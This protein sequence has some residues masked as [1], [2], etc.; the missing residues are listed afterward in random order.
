M[1]KI[2]KNFEQKD[3]DKIIV[4]KFEDLICEPQMTTKEVCN[5][6]N[7][8]WDDNL[9]DPTFRGEKWHGDSSFE[10]YHGL[11]NKPLE[12]SR[13]QFNPKEKLMISLCLDQF[14]T[15]FDYVS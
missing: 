1:W 8:A 15:R 2:I 12:T 13:I 6:L 7:I 10:R 5:F 4:I 3:P 11:S 9:L 14:L